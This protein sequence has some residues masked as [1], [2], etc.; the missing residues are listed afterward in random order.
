MPCLNLKELPYILTYGTH[1]REI[2]TID[3]NAAVKEKQKSE[4]SFFYIQFSN[5][6]SFKQFP[7]TQIVPDDV[8][9]KIIDKEVFLMLDNSLEYFL[10]SADS[11]YHDIV[12]RYKIPAEQIIFL[13]AVP[14]MLDY[15]KDLA[16]RLQQ[17]EIK[18]DWFSLFEANGQDAILLSNNTETLSKK[19]KYSK[20]FLNLNRRWRLHRPLMYVLLKDMNLTNK[21]FISFAEADDHTNWQTAYSKLV[22]MYS[23]HKNIKPILDRNSDVI[24]T[25]PLYL[26]TEDLVT[27]RAQH[28]ESINEYYRDTYFSLINETTYHEGIPFLSEK[29]FKAIGMHHPFVLATAPNSLQYLKQLGYN[30]FHPYIDESYDEIVDDGD[31]MIAIVNEVKRLCEMSKEE[32]KVWRL[33]VSKIC[34]K[35]RNVM[36][37]KNKFSKPMNY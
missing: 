26:D 10:T 1:R 20:C 27:N 19:Q 18:V 23:N 31:R 34:E 16:K 33:S 4:Y 17:P 3:P 12:L 29:V 25:P 35:N 36:K 11:I 28:E 6:N 24:N 13:S 14:T 9:K 32:Y 2:V 15:V 30:T 22:S 8:L 21:G 37:R 5:E 7:I